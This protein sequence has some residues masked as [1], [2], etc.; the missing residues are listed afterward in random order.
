MFIAEITSQHPE[1]PLLI[2]GDSNVN[3]K[4]KLRV[5]SLNKLCSDF[6][7]KRLNLNHFTYHHF[8]GAGRSDSEID[9]VLCSVSVQECLTRILCTQDDPTMSSHHDAIYT[10]FK[11]PAHSLIPTSIGPISALRIPN[12]RVKIHWSPEG[13]QNY[14]S[15]IGPLLSQ[16]RSA[17]LNPSSVASMSILI[18]TTNSLLICVPSLPM[19]RHNYPPS[20]SPN[21]RINLM[22]SNKLNSISI[23]FIGS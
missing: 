13:V 4:N 6:D 1:S 3:P 18:Q 2:R 14:A 10:Q 12:S 15:C 23:I 19:N 5:S 9:V 16:L 8:L 7:L 11:I 17:W 21:P 22:L 20:L